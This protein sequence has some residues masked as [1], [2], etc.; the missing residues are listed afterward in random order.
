MK[1]LH[2]RLRDERIRRKL[3]QKDV[4]KELLVTNNTVARWE[5]GERGFHPARVREIEEWIAS[6]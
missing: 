2:Q 3:R 5:R 1:P 6:P 4:A